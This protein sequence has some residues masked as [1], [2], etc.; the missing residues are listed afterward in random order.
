MTSKLTK[1]LIKE[2]FLSNV[3]KSGIVAYFLHRKLDLNNNIN[4]FYETEHS[5]EKDNMGYLIEYFDT[6]NFGSY[7][8]I[9]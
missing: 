7:K 5:K 6:K 9:C 3:S 2:K 1:E 4:S 8:F